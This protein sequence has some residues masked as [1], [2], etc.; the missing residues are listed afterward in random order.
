MFLVFSYVC[1]KKLMHLNYGRFRSYGGYFLFRDTPNWIY[2]A[3]NG[4]HQIVQKLLDADAS[5]DQTNE[6]ETSS[7]MLAS[8]YGHEDIVELLL[9]NSAK[10]GK[11]RPWKFKNSAKIDKFWDLKIQKIVSQL[12]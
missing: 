11:F 3:Q 5:V 6:C 7:L 9:K 10:M 2:Y 1:E 8:K 4:D 12:G